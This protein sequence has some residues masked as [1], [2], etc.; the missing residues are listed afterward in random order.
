[1]RPCACVLAALLAGCSKVSPPDPPAGP[2]ATAP[3]VMA[4]APVPQAFPGTFW[5][6][7][8]REYGYWKFQYCRLELT[9]FKPSATASL[10]CAQT[11]GSV[12]RTHQQVSEDETARLRQLVK[13]SDLYG[14]GTGHIGDDATPGDGIFETLKVRPPGGGRAVVLVTSGNKTFESGARGDILNMLEDFESKM[15]NALTD[16]PPSRRG[17]AGSRR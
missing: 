2:S 15:V 16:K 5:L 13:T 10:E 8:T 3:I 7:L 6:S 11:D 12:I 14:S 9:A 4:S 1:V 17:H